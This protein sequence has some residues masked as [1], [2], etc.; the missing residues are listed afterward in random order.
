MSTVLTHEMGHTFHACDEYYAPVTRPA[1]ATVRTTLGKPDNNNCEDGCG[2]M[3]DCLMKNN[4]PEI[5]EYTNANRMGQC[6]HDHD[7]LHHDNHSSPG[8]DDAG[9]PDN[10]HGV[11]HDHVHDHHGLDPDDDVS[12]DVSD[13]SAP[14]DDDAADDTSGVVSQ[15]VPTMTGRRVPAGVAVKGPNAF[16]MP[17]HEGI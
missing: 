15:A 16:K 12:D 14:V 13:D 7:R 3:Q 9:T 11:A 17:R 5:C 1:P 6:N 10:D 2:L 4:A 8:H